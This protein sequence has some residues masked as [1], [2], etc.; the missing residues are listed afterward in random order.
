MNIACCFELH[1]GTN[2]DKSHWENQLDAWNRSFCWPLTAH[3]ETVSYKLRILNLFLYTF[4]PVCRTTFKTPWGKLQNLL[5]MKLTTNVT[6]LFLSEANN[7][8]L[9]ILCHRCKLWSLLNQRL[10][11]ALEIGL[12]VQLKWMSKLSWEPIVFCKCLCGE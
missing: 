10:F 7:I 5:G 8:Y 2:F 6:L 9:F 12:P 4:K 11:V 1:L 3:Q